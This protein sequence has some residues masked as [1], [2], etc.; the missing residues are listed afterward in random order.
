MTAPPPGAWLDPLRRALDASPAPVTFFFRDDDVGWSDDRLF[1]LLD[2][3][4]RYGLPIDLAV[5]PA[6]LGP[7]LARRL[8]RTVSD[9]GDRVSV[10]QHGFAHVNHEHEGR[11]CEFGHARPGL[12]QRGDIERGRQRLQHLLGPLVRPIF[13]PPWNRCTAETARC[14]VDLD[15]R[16]LSRDVSA[17]PLNQAGLAELSIRLDWHAHRRGVRLSPNE[18]GDALATA[19]RTT[20]PIGIMFHHAVIDEAEHEAL[21]QLLSVLAGHH[22]ARSAGIMALARDEAVGKAQ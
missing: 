18:W 10:H 3:F 13:T 21:R 16:V 7:A 1:T 19:V 22:H 2:L 4:A 12:D 17:V 8:E 20:G 9:S 11:K 14:L 5:I 6:E 15:F